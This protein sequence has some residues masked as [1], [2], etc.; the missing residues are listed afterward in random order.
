LRTSRNPRFSRLPLPQAP[1]PYWGA[2]FIGRVFL[3][4]MKNDPTWPPW[5]P[6]KG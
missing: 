2:F 3:T 6:L 5:I 1:H 4:R